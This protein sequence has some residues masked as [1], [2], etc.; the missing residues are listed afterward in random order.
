MTQ[1]KLAQAGKAELY[2]AAAATFQTLIEK[3]PQGQYLAQALLNR[4]DCL[5]HRN[6]KKEAAQLYDQLLE[7]FPEDKLL[8]DALYALGVTREELGQP[9]EAGKA[10]DA[11]LKK[12]PEHQLSAEVIMRRGETLFSAK[13]YQ[14]AA[15][16]FASAAGRPDFA[17]ADYA[18]M[19]RAASLAQLKNYAEAAAALCRRAGQVPPVALRTHRQPAG[20]QVLLPGRQPCRSTLAAGQGVGRRRAIRPRGGPLAGPQPD[21]RRQA[22]RGTGGGGEGPGRR[23]P[24]AANAAIDDGPGRR[25]L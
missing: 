18:T 13:E 1:F 2:D 15:D 25:G 22:G 6:R 16:W 12:F 9:E 3:Y 23:R 21:E 4:G 8:A 10:Y 19:R 5:Y 7:K 17:L 14:A 20:R 11:F 24:H